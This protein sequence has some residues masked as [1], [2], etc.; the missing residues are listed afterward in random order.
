MKK[1]LLLTIIIGTVLNAAAQDAKQLQQYKYRIPKY[2]AITLQGSNNGYTINQTTLPTEN[3]IGG[4]VYGQYNEIRSTDKMLSNFNIL[5]IASFG[6]ANN[7]QQIDSNKVKRGDFDLQIAYNTKLY[8]TKLQYIELRAASQ[9]STNN[10]TIIKNYI[11]NSYKTSDKATTET[12]KLTLGIG[13]GRIENVTDMQNA[14]WLIKE[15]QYDK[16]LAKTLTEQEVYG[17]AQAITKGRNT[18]ILDFRRNIKYLL[19]IV[20]TYLQSIKAIAKNDINYFTDLNDI[21]YFANNSTR[22][23]GYNAYIKFDNQLQNY[24]A[25][26]INKYLNNNI[27]SK[28]KNE[29]FQSVI[30]VGY[31]KEKPINL[32]EQVSYGANINIA[33]NKLKLRT[34]QISNGIIVS[35]TANTTKPSRVTINGTIGYAIYPNTRTIAAF[36]LSAN[37][38][39]SKYNGTKENATNIN[40]GFKGT[41]FIS[42]NTLFF[43]QVR[44]F[45]NNSS[46]SYIINNSN[47]FSANYNTAVAINL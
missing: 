4:S 32:K 27:E 11:P 41:Y 23:S 29:G 30:T 36:D 26:N 25:Y 45:Y 34:Q 15:L 8:N 47:Y 18:R 9:Y 37:H 13:K 40:V 44:G 43:V 19:K 24:K 14:L 2:R 3:G 12:V 42:Y 22:N 5:N 20:D 35:N 39:Q 10:A 31:I 6:N 38:Y 46:S 16:L 1:N 28:F 21:V 7:T 33:T 17:L